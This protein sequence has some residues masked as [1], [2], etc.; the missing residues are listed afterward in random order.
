LYK[1]GFSSAVP[2]LTLFSFSYLLLLWVFSCIL[3]DMS[4]LLS[5]TTSFSLLQSLGEDVSVL[6]GG[7]VD[8]E[9]ELE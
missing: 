8:D 2:L 6:T 5:L 3:V 1:A 4:V 7:A 9:E